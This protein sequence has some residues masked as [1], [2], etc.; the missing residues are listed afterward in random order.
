MIDGPALPRW[1]PRYTDMLAEG[2]DTRPVLVP[3]SLAGREKIGRPCRYDVLCRT[4]IELP[5]YPD[6]TT[7]ELD[8]ITST[9]VTISIDIPGRRQLQRRTT[10]MAGG[11]AIRTMQK[12]LEISMINTGKSIAFFLQF[13]LVQTTYATGS[14]IFLTVLN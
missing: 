10:A 4:D 8:S 12:I 7:L 13:L 6:R 3:I 1:T 2:E 5:S 9:P 11:I 14:A